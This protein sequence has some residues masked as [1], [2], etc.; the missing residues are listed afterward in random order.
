[1]ILP[2]QWLNINDAREVHAWFNFFPETHEG[3]PKNA[4]YGVFSDAPSLNPEPIG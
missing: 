1:M 4:G 2:Y 3:A